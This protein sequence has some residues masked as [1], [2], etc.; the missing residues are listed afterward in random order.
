MVRHA[1]F[2]G[3]TKRFLGYFWWWYDPL[4]MVLAGGAGVIS[5]IG[6]FQ[7]IFRYDSFRIES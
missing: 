4:P 2:E 3:Q 6:Q 5:V 7:R 1:N